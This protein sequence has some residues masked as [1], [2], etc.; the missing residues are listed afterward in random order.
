MTHFLAAV[1]LTL[2]MLFWYFEKFNPL[3]TP[4]GAQGGHAPPPPS[5]DR[6]VKTIKATAHN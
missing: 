2:C 6:R 3:N 4:L 1:D 5:V